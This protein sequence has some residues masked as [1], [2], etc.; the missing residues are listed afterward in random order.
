MVGKETRFDGPAESV[1][2]V[3]SGARVMSWF[4][5]ADHGVTVRHHY[6][7]AITDTGMTDLT[8]T[9]TLARVLTELGWTPTVLARRLN[10]FAALHGRNERIH[11]KT[12][13]KWLRGDQPRS[14]WPA[15][16]TTL[17]TDELQRPVTTADLGWGGTDVEAVSAISG[18]ILPWTVAGSLHATRVVTDAGNMDRRI[19][20][21]LLGATAC[22]PAH[23]WLLARSATGVAR[24]SGLPLPAG[25]VDDLDDIVGRLRRMDDQ[26]GSGTLLHLVRAN[27][28]HV[29]GLLDQR[30][31]TDSVGRRLHATAGE[32]MRLGGWLSFDSGHHPQAQRYWIAAL[33]AAHAAGDRALGANVVG[34]MSLQ[35][36][37]LS[38][39]RE[40]A[41]LAET[42][43][44]GYPGATPRVAAI[45][46]LRA[47]E[48]YACDRATTDCRRALDSAFDRLGDTPSSSG[49]PGWC[50][51][52]DEAQ[53]H[54][55]A[56][57][58]YLRLE[59]WGRARQHLRTALHLQDLS[60]AREGALRHILL[61]QT[62]LRQDRPEVDHAVSLAT[63]AVETLTGEVDS[64]RCVG[65]LTRLVSD[66][67][68][69]RRR[70]AVRQLTEQATP[71]LAIS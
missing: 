71:L 42:A 55:M 36:K 26:L 14:P 10:S 23:E 43:R 62:Y 58:C 24:C 65:H 64:A 51:W 12:P 63:R 47:A 8:N 1:P 59:D 37:D 38:Q 3:R 70:P 33:H 35:A 52:L 31:Y 20:L 7:I 61:A 29:L 15:L 34:S 11:A 39:I 48:A 4:R 67:A 50:Y 18:L 27:L 57:F 66:L 60:C 6:P 32:L 53:A 49:E 40:S 16:T 9:S 5:A 41:T 56:G 2:M 44:A 45:C 22:A 68:P 21:T 25:V 46:D 54:A 13:Y 17:L 30:R 28:R 69:Y 19:V